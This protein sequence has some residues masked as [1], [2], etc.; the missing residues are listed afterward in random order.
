MR[1]YI[2]QQK[3]K[4][5]ELNDKTDTLNA[6]LDKATGVENYKKIILQ[7]QKISSDPE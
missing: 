6:R 2:T 3:K 7:K 5:V 1:V 4:I